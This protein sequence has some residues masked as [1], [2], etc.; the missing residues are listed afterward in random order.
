MCLHAQEDGVD[1]I[2]TNR[3]A[4]DDLRQMIDKVIENNAARTDCRRNPTAR[5]KWESES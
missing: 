4:P 2:I 3:Y 1:Y 5:A